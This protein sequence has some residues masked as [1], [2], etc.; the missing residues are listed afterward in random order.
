MNSDRP[1]FTTSVT[2]TIWVICF[3]LLV[4]NLVIYASNNI[5]V[6]TGQRIQEELKTE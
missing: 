6:E 2:R 3:W 1:P 5:D 4:I